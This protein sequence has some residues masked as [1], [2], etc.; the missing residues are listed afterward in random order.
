[1]E[2]IKY[3]HWLKIAMTESLYYFNYMGAWGVYESK[4]KAVLFFGYSL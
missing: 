2:I 1:M 3:F 4:I